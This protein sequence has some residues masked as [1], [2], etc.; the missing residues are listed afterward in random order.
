MTGT[1]KAPSGSS[2]EDRGNWVKISEIYLKNFYKK[3][4]VSHSSI[5]LSK[6]L[7]NFSLWRH[8][9]LRICTTQKD[10]FNISL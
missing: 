1:P 8:D 3:F 10:E 2:P 9:R 7:K 5:P 6:F 4:V